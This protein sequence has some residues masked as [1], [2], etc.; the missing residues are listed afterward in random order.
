ARRPGQAMSFEEMVEYVLEVTRDAAAAEPGQ[1]GEPVV[2]P[3]DPDL[4]LLTPREREIAAL[5]AR[6]LANREIAARL[7]V[8]QRTVETHVHNILGKLELTTR[9]QL[10]FWAV[11]HGLLRS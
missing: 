7:V 11:E 9:G 1:A 10:A 3:P 8:A 4:A 5:V 2:S 6:G